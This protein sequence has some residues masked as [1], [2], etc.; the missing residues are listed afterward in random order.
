M[1]MKIRTGR[2]EDLEL[3]YSLML[4]LFPKNE[5]K[6]KEK[7]ADLMRKGKYVLYIAENT[8]SSS[9][10]SIIGFCFVYVIHEYKA[11][12]IDYFAINAAYQG[13]GN[14]AFLFNNLMGNAGIG[15]MNLFA[16]LEIPT[17][18]DPQAKENRRIRFYERQGIKLLDI[19]Y[20]LPINKK[21]TP[22]HIGFRPASTSTSLSCEMLCEVIREIMNNIHDDEQD[23]PSVR[24]EIIEKLAR[25]H[26]PIIFTSTRLLR[27]PSNS[28]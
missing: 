28:P 26:S 19:D 23:M 25:S 9:E 21:I 11:A 5:L 17:S 16:E 10:E 12:W 7:I 13:S 2:I 27:L 20:K 1:D 22:M 3:I 15:D 8:P 4:A 24:D 6:T 14:G 18:T